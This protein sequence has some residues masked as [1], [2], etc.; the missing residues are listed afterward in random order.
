MDYKNLK[1][2]ISEKL[3]NPSIEYAS[4]AI[5]AVFESIAEGLKE[6][7]FVSI[8][9]WG[10]YSIKKEEIESELSGKGENSWGMANSK[11]PKETVWPGPRPHHTRPLS[12][13][14]FYGGI[15]SKF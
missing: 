4:K 14:S 6:D 15:K 3:K 5:N 11:K 9:A 10:E 7:N 2:R 1:I 13:A 8:G 12:K